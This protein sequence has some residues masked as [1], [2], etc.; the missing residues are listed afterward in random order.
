MVAGFCM[1]ACLADV[2]SL[3]MAELTQAEADALLAM[4]KFC[5]ITNEFDFPSSGTKLQVPLVS[6]DAEEKFILDINRVNFKISQVTFQNRTRS[7]IILARLDID[8]PPHTNP[9]GVELPCPHLHIYRFGHGDRWA[10]PLPAGVFS[11]VS[12]IKATCDEFMDW[13]NVVVP[14]SFRPGFEI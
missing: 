5:T 4:E 13:A 8:D 12:K 9:D 6:N 10:F 3:L 1:V 2:F 11:D 7:V 14:P